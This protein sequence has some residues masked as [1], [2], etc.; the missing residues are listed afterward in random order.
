MKRNDNQE[1]QD[2]KCVICR[3]PGR[4]IQVLTGPRKIPTIKILCDTHKRN[5]ENFKKNLGK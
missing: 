5:F 1:E 4:K 3:N 2:M